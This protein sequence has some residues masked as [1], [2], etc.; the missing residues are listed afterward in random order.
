[1]MVVLMP[2]TSLLT[3]FQGRYLDKN[4]HPLTSSASGGKCQVVIDS[5]EYFGLHQHEHAQRNFNQL[6]ASHRISSCSN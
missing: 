1:M 6:V 5:D 4:S 2:I 3:T